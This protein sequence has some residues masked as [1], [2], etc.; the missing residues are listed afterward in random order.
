MVSHPILFKA[1]KIHTIPCVLTQLL[2]R[3]PHRSCLTV[4]VL[5]NIGHKR[6]KTIRN[7]CCLNLHC[8]LVLKSPI[9]V[10]P[11]CD[12]GKSVAGGTS[13][14]CVRPGTLFPL[15]H[16]YCLC[17]EGLCFLRNFWIMGAASPMP[18]LGTPLVSLV[19]PLKVLL[20]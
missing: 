15:H 17:N 16:P 10:A 19:K 3:V 11:A 4:P 13:S 12:I 20:V 9:P 8:L 2:Y 7:L 6:S 14:V 5:R 1:G 18:S